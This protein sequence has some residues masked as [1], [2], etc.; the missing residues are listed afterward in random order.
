MLRRFVPFVS[1]VLCLA[2]AGCSSYKKDF[3]HARKAEEGGHFADAL[4]RYQR[5]LD[6]T[7]Q[8][9]KRSELHTRIAEC[10]IQLDQFQEAYSALQKALADDPQNETAAVAMASLL[11]AAHDTDSAKALLDRVLAAHPKNSDA[12]IL[13]ASLDISEGQNDHA[14]ALYRDTLKLAPDAVQ[15]A[16]AY[17]ELLNGADRVS[18]GRRVLEKAAAASQHSPSDSA[19]AWLALARLEEQEGNVVGAESDYRSAKLADHSDKTVLRYAQFLER[20]GRIAEARATLHELSTEGTK[21]RSEGDLAF[22][23]GRAPEAALLYSKS[24]AQ[25]GAPKTT[26]TE[27]PRLIEAEI[28]AGRVDHAR[29]LLE[30]HRFALDAATADLLQSEIELRSG[31][32]DGA[33]KLATDAV[34][35]APDSAAAHT[36]SGM[37]LMA[38]GE[39]DKAFA[40]WTQAIQDSDSYTPARVALARYLLAAGDPTEAEKAIVK[41]VQDEPANIAALALYARALAAQSRFDLADSVLERAKAIDANAGEVRDAIGDLAT[42]Q[43]QYGLAMAAYQ[44]ALSRDPNDDDALTGLVRLYRRGHVTKAMITQLETVAMHPPHSTALLLLAGHLYADHQEFTDA[45]R[46][47]NA[48]AT[49]EQ[50]ADRGDSTLLK[51]EA[52]EN[53]GDVNAAISG[54][55]TAMVRGDRTGIAANNLAWI[56]VQQRQFDRALELA[57]KARAL[58]PA[59]PAVLDTTALAYIGRHQYPAAVDLLKRAI[60]AAKKGGSDT[61][62]LA[63]M[64]SHLN[65]ALAGMNA[66]AE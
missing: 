1:L 6:S 52:A 4:N 34:S 51:A 43:Q 36:Q 64:S 37:V 20:S 55:E 66:K 24:Q 29:L 59:D 8:A 39:S 65:S 5:L 60:G 19:D 21:A 2:L 63:Q 58:R 57:Q 42:A 38:K 10:L 15:V 31:N 53:R 22:L 28:A 11:F 54:Y 26:D 17:A 40:E 14:E 9:Q 62:Q 46:C 61:Q 13:R 12:V 23:A 56:Y 41:V 45:R 25:I 32:L 7:P 18:E 33:Q 35:F 44:S 48:A 49:L 16:V 27:A 47:F 3:A 50:D 30:E